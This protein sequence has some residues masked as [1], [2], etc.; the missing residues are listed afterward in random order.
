MRPKGEVQLIDKFIT[1]KRLINSGIISKL[2]WGILFTEKKGRE[3]GQR[4]SHLLL[5]AFELLKRLPI[6]NLRTRES[7]RHIGEH[8]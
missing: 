2:S 3:E 7:P 8:Q 4:P 5:N 6:P 1:N